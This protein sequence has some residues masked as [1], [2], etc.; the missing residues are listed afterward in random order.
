MHDPTAIMALI[1]PDLFETVKA[2]VDVEEV[3]R[4]TSGQ[5]VADFS[6]RYW[7]R[8]LQTTILTTVKAKEYLREFLKRLSKFSWKPQSPKQLQEAEESI[9]ASQQVQATE[10]QQQQQ[11]QQQSSS[12][13]YL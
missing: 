11:Q 2:T 13:V 5:T 3:G 8:P 9:A 12:Y 1:R 6:G 7:N 4:L 10:P